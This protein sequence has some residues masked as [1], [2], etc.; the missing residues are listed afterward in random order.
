MT[1]PSRV[2]M[3]TTPNDVIAESWPDLCDKLYAEAW[4]EDIDRW[5]SPYVFRGLSCSDYEL[6]HSLMRLGGDYADMECHLLGSFKKYAEI[7]GGSGEMSDWK[8]ITLAQHHGLPSRLIDFTHS[9]FVA[10]HF[11]TA[12]MR[13]YDR[14]GVIWCVD[15][16]KAHQLLPG[17]GW[18]S[19][20]LERVFSIGKLETTAR[21]L[22]EFD[23]V[24]EEV[25]TVFFEPP[26]MDARIV[27]QF[28]LFSVM[29]SP[30]SR[31]DHWLVNHPYLYKRV[32]VPRELKWEVRCKLDDANI[33]ERMLF[34][35][36]DG[37][38]SMLARY[39]GP[40]PDARKK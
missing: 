21:D 33:T 31:L 23:R 20:R 30:T 19:L 17:A 36:L 13:H 2:K 32:I 16:K 9:P 3:E 6:I 26:S 11:A 10:L 7:N 12:N 18:E 8:W 24:S 14:D 29:S 39:Y 38:A 34:P 37:L 28:G 1:F 25:V 5:R 27:N 4:R 15:S 40:R 35:G 22:I